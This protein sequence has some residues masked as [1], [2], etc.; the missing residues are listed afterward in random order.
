MQQFK[1][2]PEDRIKLIYDNPSWVSYV[3]DRLCHREYQLPENVDESL[4]QLVEWYTNK[5]S[6]RVAYAGRKLKKVFAE[7]PPKEQRLVG[8]ALLTGSK[9][10]CEWICIRLNNYKRWHKSEWV[11]TWHPCYAQAVEEC[12]NR[13]HLVPCGKLMVQFQDEEVVRQYLDELSTTDYYFL[14][15]RRFV[16]RPWFELDVEKLKDCTHINAYLSVMARTKEGISREEARRLMYQW[17]AI[18]LHFDDDIGLKLSEGELFLNHRDNERRIIN[19]WGFDTALFYLL[20][21]GHD[22]VVEEILMWDEWVRRTY[23]A[24]TPPSNTLEANPDKMFREA[25]KECFPEDL[26]YFLNIWGE[27]GFYYES[28]GRP[29]TVPKIYFRGNFE[30][31]L[32]EGDPQAKKLVKP[33]YATLMELDKEMGA[34]DFNQLVED[35]PHLEQLIARLGL[36]RMNG[37]PINAR[38]DWAD[39]EVVGDVPF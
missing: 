8:L 10:D 29:F 23:F 18:I 38:G 26:R 39:E 33:P 35:N 5:R 11:I 30:P 12:W 13:Y 7:L 34:E 36:H 9:A 32:P 4:E 19:A 20:R 16:D 17:I 14:L 21:M 22:E 1:L 28:L 3:D 31:R 25:A 24:M 15:C 2:T 37:G 6:K 27:F